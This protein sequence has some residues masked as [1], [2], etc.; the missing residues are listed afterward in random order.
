VLAHLDYYL[1]NLQR[2]YK[3]ITLRWLV[4]EMLTK[5]YYK[6]GDALAETLSQQL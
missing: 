6:T 4:L 1:E 2:V 5:G 3:E